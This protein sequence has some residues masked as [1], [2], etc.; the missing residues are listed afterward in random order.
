MGTLNSESRCLDRFEKMLR[1]GP[2]SGLLQIR[3]PRYDG[4]ATG[5]IL[6]M[7]LEFESEREHRVIRNTDQGFGE[8]DIDFIATKNWSQK[9]HCNEGLGGY[10][11]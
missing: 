5:G 3:R 1:V 8:P 2:V 9:Q 6:S 11:S 10:V 7:P 4:Y